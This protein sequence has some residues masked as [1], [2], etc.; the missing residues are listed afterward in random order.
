MKSL[1]NRLPNRIISAVAVR[2]DLT[3]ARQR[4]LNPPAY[5]DAATRTEGAARISVARQLAEV[6]PG[7]AYGCVDWYLYKNSNCDPPTPA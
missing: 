1:P 7:L 4:A 2:A 5:S 3:E 6:D